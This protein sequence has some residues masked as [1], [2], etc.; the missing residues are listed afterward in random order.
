VLT[1]VVSKY[2]HKVMFLKMISKISGGTNWRGRSVEG[3]EASWKLPRGGLFILVNTCAFP[4]L[5]LEINSTIFP[6]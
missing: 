2:K 3:V 4:F 6:A 1:Y 5:K